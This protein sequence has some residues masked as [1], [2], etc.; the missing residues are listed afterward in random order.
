MKGTSDALVMAFSTDSSTA[1]MPVTYH[2]LIKNV[3][4]REKSASLA[5]WWGP[6]LTMMEPLFTRQ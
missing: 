2:S 4:L 3:G 5:R 1:T 6:T